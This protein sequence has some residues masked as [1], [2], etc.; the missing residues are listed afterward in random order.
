MNGWKSTKKLLFVGGVLALAIA[1]G[2]GFYFAYW[3]PAHE[4]A[5][6][7]VP[8]TGSSGPVNL[9]CG[10]TTILE[11]DNGGM[12]SF[13]K[14]DPCDLVVTVKPASLEELPA[15]LPEGVTFVDA[16]TV[17]VVQNGAALEFLP[18]NKKVTISFANNTDA[19][20]DRFL[21]VLHWDEE[22][23]WKEVSFDSR[24]KAYSDVTGIFVLVKL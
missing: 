24:L 21:S 10:S 18:A 2:F 12:V 22:T 3:V 6:V 15:S 13:P 8:V 11:M 23:G 1:L 20:G 4:V 9:A 16:T 5:S 19:L 17:T 7:T 14:I